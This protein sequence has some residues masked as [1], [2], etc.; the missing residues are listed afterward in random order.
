M[1]PEIKEIFIDSI[2]IPTCCREGHDDCEHVVNR[3]SLR[4]NRKQIAL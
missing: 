2:L 4:K 3:E 1:E